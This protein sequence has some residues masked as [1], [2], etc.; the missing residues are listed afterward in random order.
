VLE[1]VLNRDV[2]QRDFEVGLSLGR[3]QRSMTGHEKTLYG[4]AWATGGVL[5][6]SH[7]AQALLG[8]QAARRYDATLGQVSCVPLSGD[9]GPR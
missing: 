9:A 3:G 4:A 6:V 8:Y 7:V 2:L 5:A 1:V